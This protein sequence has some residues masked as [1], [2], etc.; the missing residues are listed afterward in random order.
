M[1]VHIGGG[2]GGGRMEPTGISV[3]PASEDINIAV[4]LSVKYVTKVNGIPSSSN[5]CV[6]TV[7]LTPLG[8]IWQSPSR[9]Y[10]DVPSIRTNFSISGQ[11][12]IPHSLFLSRPVLPFLYY[13]RP[14]YCLLVRVYATVYEPHVTNVTELLH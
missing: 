8:V 2:G 5:G 3:L 7:L 13:P 9:A 1:D 6:I 14:L 4:Q 12:I 10:V 11:Y